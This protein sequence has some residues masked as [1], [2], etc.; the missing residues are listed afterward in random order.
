M[1]HLP[2]R[3]GSSR[4]TESH[5]SGEASLVSLVSIGWLGALQLRSHSSWGAHRG[6]QQAHVRQGCATGNVALLSLEGLL[7]GSLAAWVTPA[8]IFLSQ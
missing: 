3:A 1:C 4:F 2:K 6:C 5:P 8:G 7:A